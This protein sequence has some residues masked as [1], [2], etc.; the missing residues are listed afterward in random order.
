MLNHIEKRSYWLRRGRAIDARIDKC[1][2]KVRSI[3]AKVNDKTDDELLAMGKLRLRTTFTTD[4]LM[5]SVAEYFGPYD[6][7]R[8]IRACKWGSDI[9]KLLRSRFPQL[10]IFRLP[11]HF[12]HL[13]DASGNA[14]MHNQT[15]ISVAVGLCYSSRRPLGP[16]GKPAVEPRGYLGP[17]V[18]CYAAQNTPEEVRSVSRTCSYT[19]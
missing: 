11:G 17:A 3:N 6:A 4:D 8:L 7:G 9:I 13:V 10:T 15:L 5:K 16:D 18:E 12:P 19:E 1:L 2:R 14:F